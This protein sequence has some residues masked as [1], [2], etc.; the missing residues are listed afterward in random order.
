LTGIQVTT[1][2]QDPFLEYH[3]GFPIG[4]LRYVYFNMREHLAASPSS[5]T[6][7]GLQNYEGAWIMYG[8]GPDKD[9]W[10]TYGWIA[11]LVYI[12]YDPTNGTVST[13]NVFRTQKH[14]EGLQ[15]ERTD[16]LSW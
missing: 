8:V 6:W 16:I 7:R 1:L 4:G 9:A 3:P 14:S 12:N 11:S 15:K 2:F 13:G 5:L 10:N